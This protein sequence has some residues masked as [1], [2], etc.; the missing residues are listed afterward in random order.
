MARS[1]PVSVASALLLAAAAFLAGA[2]N[3]VAGGGSFLT[4]PALV[5]T[6]VP[7][8]I[9]NA[10]STVALF[11]G[12]FASAWAYRHDFQNFP[13]VKFRTLLA[14]SLVG[15]ILGAMLLLLTPQRT[16]DGVIPWLLL[17]ATLVFAFA[18]RLTPR[19]QRRV[20]IGAR[21]LVVT[22][23][24]VAVYGGYFGGA[25]GIM[26]LSAW[27]LFG[28]TDLKMMN[29]TKTLLAGAL[30]AVAVSLFIPAG[31]V[32]WPQTLVMLAGALAGGY[33]GARLARRVD[34]RHVR[35]AVIAISVT[36]TV[37]F[38]ARSL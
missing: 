33:L 14:V 2:M 30:N 25:I 11:P 28:L 9:A 16:F 3:A 24:F 1:P 36:M 4:F 22:Q 13:G 17:L 29:A 19:L 27:S 20:R 5:F 8:I 15:G 23:F 26:M 21:T 10:S 38:F 37:V 18:P 35:T 7:S 32:W 12:S 31:K 6:G 34:Q